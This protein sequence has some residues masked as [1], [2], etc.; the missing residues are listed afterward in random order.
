MFS[1][2]GWVG[3]SCIAA[4]TVPVSVGYVEVVI[5]I[6]VESMHGT[7][8]GKSAE[9]LGRPFELVVR[10]VLGGWLVECQKVDVEW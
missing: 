4:L 3:G 9:N 7:Q 5:V 2:H 6:C 10:L 8:L 1:H